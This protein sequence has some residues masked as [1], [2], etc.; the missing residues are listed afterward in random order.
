MDAPTL[1]IVK[2]VI[3][4][5]VII[6]GLKKQTILLDVDV[7]NVQL[8]FKEIEGECVRSLSAMIPVAHD[9][10]SYFRGLG[11]L[12]TLAFDYP[13]ININMLQTWNWAT[14]KASHGV[15]MQR[16]F[17]SEHRSVFEICKSSN[18]KV[19]VDYDDFLFDIPTDNPTYFN[20][21]NDQIQTNIKF[22]LEH[23]DFVTVSTKELARQYSSFGNQKRDV[24]RN[25]IRVI[26]NAIDLGL[27]GFRDKPLKRT[28]AFLWR[29]SRT[30][31]RDVFLMADQIL[32]VST[33]EFSKDWTWHFIGDNLWLITDQMPHLRTY[34]MKPMD[35]IEYHGHIFELAPSAMMVPLHDSVFNRCKSN[36]ALIEGAFSGAVTIAPEWEEWTV[37]GAITYKTKEQFEDALWAVITGKIDIEATAR[38]SW[39]HVR[40]TLS[41]DRINRA[42]AEILCE[43]W[44]CDLTDLGSK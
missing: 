41:L 1:L 10:T 27:F 40:E 22:I 9:A 38:N 12:G 11:P 31:Q 5:A 42:R 23:A 2:E 43:M 15:F 33:N 21:M 4:S 13:N 36:I 26:P 37:P 16:P 20:Y 32:K 6:S 24:K 17:T 39:D 28:K 7:K 44:G 14:L 25:D 29:G 35:V 3:L 30:H 19:W 8:I 18:K 34:V